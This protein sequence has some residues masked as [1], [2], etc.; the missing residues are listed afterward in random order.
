MG[1]SAGKIADLSFYP[2]SRHIPAAHL[3]ARKDSNSKELHGFAPP[4]LRGAVKSLSHPVGGLT[5]SELLSNVAPWAFP[6]GF[7]EPQE[8]S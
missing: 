5:P 8:C 2:Q 1:K 7:C 3:S 6:L 4:H